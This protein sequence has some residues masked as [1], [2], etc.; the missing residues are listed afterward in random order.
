MELRGNPNLY[1]YVES[2][3]SDTAKKYQP[4]GTGAQFKQEP[5]YRSRETILRE[6]RVTMSKCFRLKKTR[7]ATWYLSML[8]CVL[9]NVRQVLRSGTSISF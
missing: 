8:V 4:N 9:R 1:I 6:S 3:L 5:E 7:T 2:T